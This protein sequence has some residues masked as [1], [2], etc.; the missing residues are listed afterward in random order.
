MTEIDRSLKK[1][2]KRIAGD[3]RANR[4]LSKEQEQAI[5]EIAEAEFKKMV[6]KHTLPGVE[7]TGKEGEDLIK[8]VSANIAQ[9]L[10]DII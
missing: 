4:N 6:S 1:I 5:A 10:E 2:A 3:Y 8:Q 7:I 9:R